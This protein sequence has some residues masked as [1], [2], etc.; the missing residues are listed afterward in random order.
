MAD[1]GTDGMAVSGY[2]LETRTRCA[3]GEAEAVRGATPGLREKFG[4]EPCSLYDERK[5][6]AS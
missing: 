2:R 6:S 3:R 5:P 4:D 1:V